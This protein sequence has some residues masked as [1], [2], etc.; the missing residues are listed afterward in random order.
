MEVYMKP[1]KPFYLALVILMMLTQMS[2]GQNAS[3][4]TL[5]GNYGI[6][7]G[8]SKAVFAAGSLVFYGLGNKV[9]IASFSNPAAPVKIGSVILTEVVEALVRTSI[10]STQYLVVTGGSK[11]WLINVQSPTNP[12]LVS[13]VDVA[14][15]T[16]CEG[17]ATS[18]SYAYVAAGD[19]GFKVYSIATPSAPTLVASIDSLAYCE[20]VVIS[21][22]YAFIAS[23]TP[24]FV[25]RSFIIDISTPSAP[26]YKATMLGYGGYHQY[27][28]VRSG[29]A[30]IC[31]Y[32]AGLQ[33]INVADV[34]NPVNVVAIPSG[35]R[36]ASIVFDGNYAYVA[37]GDLGMHIYNVSNPA[38]P[39]FV[40][41]LAT[42]GRAAFVSYGAITI[43]GSP[44]GHIYVAN[45]VTGGVS[46]INVSDPASPTLSGFLAVTP[47]ASGNAF[48]PFYDNG[49][50]YVAYGSAGL[51]IIDVTTPSQPTN[52]S[53][54]ALSGESRG[55]VAV[56]NYV[57]VAAY[58]SGVHVVDA[59][60]A[61]IPVKLNTINTSRARG[62]AVNGNYV[63][64]ATR[65]S[66]LVVLS[67]TDPANPTWLT[68]VR[69]IDVENVASAGNVVGTSF[70]SSIRFYDVTDP[71]NPV[72]KGSTPSLRTGNEGFAIVGNYAYVPDGDSLKIFDITDLMTPT[73][74]SKIKTGGYG[75]AAAVAG[76]YCYVAAEKAGVRAINISNPAAPVEDGYYD[77][78]PEARGVAAN[79]GYVYVAQRTDGLSVYRNDLLT[80]VGEE[81][82]TPVKFNLVQNYPNPFNPTTNIA[83]DLAERAFVT[84]GVYNL[85]GQRVAVLV[86]KQM[87][88]GS[89]IVP[90]DASALPSGIYLYRMQAN[91]FS[92]TRK[93]LLLK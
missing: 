76:N 77:G 16:T 12:S 28:G 1:G 29:Y 15:G 64:V 54:L 46:A 10:S 49:K 18:G 87:P 42:T 60:N 51:R 61:A 38:A 56:G 81:G 62:V 66:G 93:M 19:A 75:F 84:L 24:D 57:Y 26:V 25:G 33:V 32:N 34:T 11:M 82:T 59:T 86:Q 39:T 55:V 30:Y 83:F 88:A 7:E 53:T 4:V 20:S 6:G 35:Y 14:P 63:Y 41:S 3:N 45:R 74:I 23:N 48:S 44:K 47:A 67:V 9:Q 43:G 71:A 5:L 70:Y 79:G 52:L 13:T 91:S 92:S 69:G 22:P 21:A 17:V 73:L 85:L 27:M 78:V 68:S 37:V 31:D 8:E 65:D 50:V 80:S 36:T 89:F 58:D 40:S 90:F 72:E 2:F